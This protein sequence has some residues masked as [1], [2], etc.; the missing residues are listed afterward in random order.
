MLKR[1]L[2][3]NG[4]AILAVVLNHARVWGLIAMISWTDRYR[5]VTVPNYDQIGNVEYYLLLGVEGIVQF[6]IPTFLFVSGYFIAIATGKNRTTIPWNIVINRIKFLAVPYLLWFFIFSGLLVMEGTRFTFLGYLKSIVTG[7]LLGPYYFV[8][9]LIQ[10]YLLSPFIVPL[11]KKNWKLLL[12][13]AVLIQLFTQILLYFEIF[14]I[15]SPFSQFH[16]L[17]LWF[18]PTRLLWFVL[19][20]IIGSH[21]QTFKQSLD[22]A[23]NL[24]L[25]SIIVFLVLATLEREIIFR[26]KVSIPVETTAG[27]LYALSFIFT[28]LG[29]SKVPLPFKS[30]L[31]RIGGKSFGIYLTHAPVQRYISRIIYH[32]IPLLLAHQFLFV[33]IIFIV[34]LGA[35]ILLM[36]AVRRSPFSRYYQYMFG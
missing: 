22:K 16:V 24:F 12:V 32:I 17:P 2:F 1:L 13:V 33:P 29:F 14:Q 6:A 23:K 9:L 4:L 28:A 18:F 36:E 26:M 10:Y 34:G 15:N 30:Q 8:P 5:P 3:L 19:G 21:I 27:S 11:A 31:E 25:V 35:P 7:N 20:I